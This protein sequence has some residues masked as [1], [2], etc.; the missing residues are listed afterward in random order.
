M[1]ATPAP[2]TSFKD[3]MQQF[4]HS[5][6]AHSTPKGT[7]RK[8]VHL[9]NAQQHLSTSTKHTHSQHIPSSDPHAS[10]CHHAAS[11]C[12]HSSSLASWDK[13]SDSNL[14]EK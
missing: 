2:T 14:K 12:H 6:L 5:D 7:S 10:K 13:N 4:S 11:N 9:K 8:V 3:L 1:K